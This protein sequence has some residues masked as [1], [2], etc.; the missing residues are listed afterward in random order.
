[1]RLEENLPK[2]KANANL[3]VND[4]IVIITFFYIKLI[5]NISFAYKNSMKTLF[6]KCDMAFHQNS[7]FFFF[8]QVQPSYSFHTHT[9]S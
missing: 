7:L 9:F 3:Q 2:L 1:M 8:T 4:L 5:L 6:L